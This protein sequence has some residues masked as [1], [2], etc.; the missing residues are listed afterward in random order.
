MK[1]DRKRNKKN[2]TAFGLR[3][4]GL[5]EEHN[6]D[7]N[8]VY[9]LLHPEMK[10]YDP[11]DVKEN[12]NNALRRIRGRMTGK[13]ATT[14]SELELLADHYGVSIDYLADRNDAETGLSPDAVRSIKSL[15]PEF[16]RH[17]SLILENEDCILT[18]IDAAISLEACSRVH[19]SPITIERKTEPPEVLEQ[20]D[21]TIHQA[22]LNADGAIFR[23]V[24]ALGDV[25][26]SL[27]QPG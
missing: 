17:L 9:K 16:K 26:R 10:N 12:D 1:S 27:Y 24:S 2:F 7:Y 5:M 3:L 22:R 15:S 21:K 6:E 4:D 18:I 14:L 11:D 23:A 19:S 8:D 20:H 13:I 25:L